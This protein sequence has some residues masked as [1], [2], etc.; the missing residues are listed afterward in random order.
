MQKGYMTSI[1]ANI[2]LSTLLGFNLLVAIRATCKQTMQFSHILIFK[3]RVIY[4][5]YQKKVYSWKI[6]AE[7]ASAQN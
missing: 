2:T 5:V 7:L 3:H 6:L 1:K 4:R